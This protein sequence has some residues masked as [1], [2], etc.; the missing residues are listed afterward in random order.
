MRK[1]QKKMSISSISMT[2]RNEDNRR[3]RKKEMIKM[4]HRASAISYSYEH[5]RYEMMISNNTQ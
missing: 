3:R 2:H 4:C 1:E 5:I